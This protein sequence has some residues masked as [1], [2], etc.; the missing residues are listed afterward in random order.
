[1]LE[2][3]SI[4]LGSCALAAGIVI[5]RGKG[6]PGWRVRGVTDTQLGIIFILVGGI[7]VIKG[8]F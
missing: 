1:M 7:F 5:S 6:Y 2:V 4:V 8:L 3:G